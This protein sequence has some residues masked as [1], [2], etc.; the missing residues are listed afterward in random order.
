MTDAGVTLVPIADLWDALK[1]EF[2]SIEQLRGVIN[3]LYDQ[4]KIM[5]NSADDT[6]VLI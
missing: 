5:L 6:V 3:E 2:N 1:T 4:N